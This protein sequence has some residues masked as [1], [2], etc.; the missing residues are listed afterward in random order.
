MTASSRNSSSSSSPEAGKGWFMSSSGQG[1]EGG[2]GT[3][4]GID[5][6]PLAAR[7]AAGY[8]FL[9][10]ATARSRALSSGL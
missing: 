7:S 4:E 8:F 5:G 2:R 1:E 3:A 6:N 9:A 10:A